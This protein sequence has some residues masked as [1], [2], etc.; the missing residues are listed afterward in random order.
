MKAANFT[1][2]SPDPSSCTHVIS[3]IE[4]ERSKKYV[5]FFSD[6]KEQVV[7]LGL[8]LGRSLLKGNPNQGGT[9]LVKV[10]NGYEKGEEEISGAIPRQKGPTFA[11][12]LFH[13]SLITK[14]KYTGHIA[15]KMRLCMCALFE[16]FCTFLKSRRISFAAIRLG[17]KDA[18]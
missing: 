1:D 3:Q 8:V 13:H 14:I 7:H 5:P 4:T 15:E 6:G 11:Q 10:R 9:S 17:G 2:L 16:C 12:N 18:H